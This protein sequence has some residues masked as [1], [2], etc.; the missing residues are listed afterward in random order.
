MC[1]GLTLLPGY[2]LADERAESALEQVLIESASTPKEHE[3]LAKYYHE[4][5][6]AAHDMAKEHK[7]MGAAYGGGKMAAA[8]AQKQHCD[9]LAE[10]YEAAAKE[11]EAMSKEHE[12]LAEK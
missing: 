7:K 12:S 6:E 9:K 2:V 3:A 4:K 11:Y 1:L 5:A 8:Q 10:S